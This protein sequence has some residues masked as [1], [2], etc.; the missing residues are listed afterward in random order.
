[1]AWINSAARNEGPAPGRACGAEIKLR[2]KL[3]VEESEVLALKKEL[4][5]H[6]P[7]LEII[8]YT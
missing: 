5:D 3:G 8:G 7:K 6:V 2:E 4:E 1:M